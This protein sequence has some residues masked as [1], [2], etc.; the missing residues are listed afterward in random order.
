MSTVQITAKH[1]FPEVV[2]VGSL[3]T[4]IESDMAWYA[5]FTRSNFEK[6]V[7]AELALKGIESYL[8]VFRETHRWKDRS[9]LIETAVFPGYVFMR[10]IEDHEMQIQVLRTSGVVRI[11]GQAG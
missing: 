7:T 4:W 3:E 2:P 5:A 8:P 11:L 10:M 6:R 1:M 9:K